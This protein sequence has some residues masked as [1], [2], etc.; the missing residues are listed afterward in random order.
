[1]ELGKSNKSFATKIQLELKQTAPRKPEQLSFSGATK[2][3]I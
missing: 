1:M 3:T 2:T